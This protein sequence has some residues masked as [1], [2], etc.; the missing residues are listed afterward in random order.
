MTTNFLCL[1]SIKRM[2]ELLGTLHAFP[3]G[4]LFK[5]GRAVLKK[6]K[7]LKYLKYTPI[8]YFYYNSKRSENKTCWFHDPPTFNNS[9][10]CLGRGRADPS[11]KPWWGP[12]PDCPS[13]VGSA[14]GCRCPLPGSR[15]IVPVLSIFIRGFIPIRPNLPPL[16]RKHH[17]DECSS[18][19]FVVSYLLIIFLSVHPVQRDQ[20]YISCNIFYKSRAILMEFGT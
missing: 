13:P 6:I 8:L 11:L 12:W 10:C 2:W 16:L 3:L 4:L 17:T 18:I 5:W 7:N 1:F 14:N 9:F 15:L 19:T 20:I